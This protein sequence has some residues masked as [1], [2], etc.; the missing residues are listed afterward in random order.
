MLTTILML[1]VLISDLVLIFKEVKAPVN[2]TTLLKFDK[3]KIME[4]ILL[5]AVGVFSNDFKERITAVGLIFII[6]TSLGK[7]RGK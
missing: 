7:L 4:I 3:I 1:C 2:S 6:G 5:I